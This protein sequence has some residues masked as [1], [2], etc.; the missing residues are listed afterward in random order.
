MTAEERIAELE[1]PVG[2]QRQQLE[3]ALAQN[4]PL[5]ARVQELEA[6]LVNA[7]HNRSQPPIRDRRARKT[8]S[9]RRTSGKKP[10]GQFELYPKR[11]ALP[12]IWCCPVVRGAV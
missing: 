8:K 4:A 11:L 6:R 7:S 3:A 1:A 5:L 10:G 12:R 2:Q 9:L